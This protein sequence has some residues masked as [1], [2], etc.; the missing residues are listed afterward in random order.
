MS[1]WTSTCPKPRVGFCWA[2]GN[3]LHGRQHVERVVDGA[4][5]VLHNFCAQKLARGDEIEDI[6]EADDREEELTP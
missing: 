3:R 2:C 6:T 4:L 1:H 5:R